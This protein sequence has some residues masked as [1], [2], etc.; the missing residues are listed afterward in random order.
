MNFS[1]FDNDIISLIKP[2]GT[3]IENIKALVETG[4]IH[5]SDVKLPLEEGDKIYR[6]LPSGLVDTYVVIDK[7]YYS[8]FGSIPA[9]YEVKVRKECSIPEDKYQSI[10]NIYNVNGI[11]SRVNINSIDNSSN[12]YN[13]PSL[14]FEEIKQ[15]LESIAEKEIQETS[16]QL[17][18]DLKNTHNTPD[19]IGN[20]QKFISTLAN[21]MTIIAPFIPAL[22]QLI[23]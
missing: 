22:T 20:Y 4:T 16:L 23:S 11:N 6:K 19:F 3:I 21:H 14:L 12:I 1:N 8:K 13:D 7:G 9:H 2:D 17:L 5:I 10:V 18:E 15:T